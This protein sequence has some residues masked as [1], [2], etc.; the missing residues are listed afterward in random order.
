MP[1]ARKRRVFDCMIFFD[2]LDLLEIRLN[3]LAPVVDTF[4]VTESPLTF[5][6]KPKPLYFHENRDRFAAFSD[7]IRHLVIEDMPGG[8]TQ[9]DHW[10]R[11]HHQRTQIARAL[12]DLDG[13]DMVILSDVDEIPR[14]SSVV[15]A[16]AQEGPKPAI[17]CFEL[18]MYRYFLDYREDMMW[19]RH[20][21]RM[22]RYADMPPLQVL[23][24]I[25]PP[26]DNPFQSF[27]R[28]VMASI[29]CGK[30][31]RRAIHRDAG[32]HFTSMGGVEPLSRKLASYSHPDA[33]VDRGLS[34]REA[35]EDR[36]KQARQAPELTRVAIDDR[37]PAF[38]LQNADRFADLFSPS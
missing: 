37:Y 30:P 15:E 35:A 17:H 22:I 29:A 19:L 28:W 7:R 9:G 5:R 12:G 23:R 11:E 25:R 24:E 31:V 6:G 16:L 32:W 13:Q 1:E 33:G 2:E 8:E 26:S 4:V 36:I 20:G 14:A 3:E 27:S 38:L 21:P 10:R 18:A 34:F